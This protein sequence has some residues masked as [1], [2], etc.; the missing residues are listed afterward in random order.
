MSADRALTKKS[1]TFSGG[2]GKKVAQP[3]LEACKGET[4]VRRLLEAAESKFS[5]RLYSVRFG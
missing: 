4:P 3:D 5:P 2:L 1:K